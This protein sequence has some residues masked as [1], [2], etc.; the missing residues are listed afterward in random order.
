MFRFVMVL[1]CRMAKERIFLRR[2]GAEEGWG[3]LEG[4]GVG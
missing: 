2:K 4:G 3:I 1:P